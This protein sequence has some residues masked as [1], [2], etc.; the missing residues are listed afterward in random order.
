MP[1]LLLCSYNYT[2]YRSSET[3][4]R[5][6]VL[7]WTPRAWM[8]KSNW[9]ASNFV[10]IKVRGQNREN[11]NKLLQQKLG[12][13]DTKQSILEIV[14]ALTVMFNMLLILRGWGHITVH[15]RHTKPLPTRTP[16]KRSTLFKSRQNLIPWPWFW[17]R[18]IAQFWREGRS[19]IYLF[20]N[21]QVF[22]AHCKIG[23]RTN[24]DKSNICGTTYHARRRL[25][26]VF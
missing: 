16:Q 25:C 3:G 11:L 18:K 14:L 22:T 20:G 17:S 4:F 13:L 8:V 2:T 6:P 15:I 5:P 9:I 10:K 19:R 21:P 12:K 7:F 24:H 1:L 26:F 23:K